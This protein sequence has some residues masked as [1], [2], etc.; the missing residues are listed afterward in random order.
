MDHTFCIRACIFTMLAAGAAMPAWAGGSFAEPQPYAGLDLFTGEL[1][2]ETQYD[3]TFNSDD[4]ASELSDRF[5]TIELTGGFALTRSLSTQV[6]FTYEPIRDPVRDRAF[7]DHGLYVEELFAQFERERFRVFAGKF[8]PSFGRA[9]DLAPGVYG[10][11]LPEEYEL[12]ERVG[13]GAALT[14]SDTALGALTLTGNLFMLDTSELSDSWL[15]ARGRTRLASGG[16]SNTESLD[17]F[18]ITLDGTDIPGFAGLGYQVGYRHQKRGVSEVADE[19][20]F[21]AALYGAKE[22]NGVG[23]EWIG[24][25]VYLDNA[26]GTRDSLT[27]YTL[28]GVVT[29]GRYNLALSYTGKPRDVAGGADLDDKQLQL[30][31][32]VEVFD[33]WGFDVGYKFNETAN[34]ESHTVGFLIG[35]AFDLKLA[36]R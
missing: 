9:W 11:D 14:R 31:M 10:T 2:F 35:R 22:M 13:A 17:S 4:P 36:R 18:S 30:S 20:G 3:N 32:G 6:H 27:Y 26:E 15:E 19:N 34:V 1:V 16:V 7:R 29:R 12:A 28:G 25:V 24:E 8:N 23:F 5:N 21:V 33:G